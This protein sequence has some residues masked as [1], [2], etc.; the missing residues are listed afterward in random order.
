[1]RANKAIYRLLP[2]LLVL[3]LIYAASARATAKQPSECQLSAVATYTAVSAPGTKYR[4]HDQAVVDLA[5]WLHHHADGS[6]KLFL[7]WYRGMCENGHAPKGYRVVAGVLILK[8][9]TR[10][11]I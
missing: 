8:G 4:Q 6:R 10:G 2:V 11:S 3:G 1:M 7:R 5:R 9:D